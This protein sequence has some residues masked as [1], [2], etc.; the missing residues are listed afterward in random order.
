MDVREMVKS[1]VIEVVK[2]MQQEQRKNGK[3]LFI[4][5]DSSA[6]E[7]HTDQFIQLKDDNIGYDSLF[8]DGETSSWIGMN[9]V[10]STSSNRIIAADGNAPSPM[11]LAKRYDGIIIPEIDLDNAAR[12]VQGLKGTIK[13]EVIF[14]ALL[15]GK[16]VLIGDDVTGV[17]RADRRYLQK[18]HLPEPYQ[19]LFQEYLRRLKELGIGFVP[20]QE[21]AAAAARKLG[22]PEQGQ[23]TAEVNA[24]TERLQEYEGKLTYTKKLLTQ[25][26]IQSQNS[27]PDNTIY[28]SKNV[29]ISPLAKDLIKEKKLTIKVMK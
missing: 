26:W 8:L 12:V 22:V 6:H 13:A 18:V 9:Q 25:K 19:V 17:K 16:F 11:E 20:V 7:G 21:M 23:K 29:I 2:S 28:L 15:L 1:A 3:V 14:A 27:I 4:F 5:C 24:D 10:E